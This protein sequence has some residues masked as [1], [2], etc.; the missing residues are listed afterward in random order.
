MEKKL[1]VILGSNGMLGSYITSF[2]KSKMRILTITRNDYNALSDISL[3][4][5]LLRKY[6]TVLLLTVGELHYY[7]KF[8][9]MM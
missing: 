2:F 4:E 6:I 9:N 7:Q 8:Q 5:I 1:L 3:L